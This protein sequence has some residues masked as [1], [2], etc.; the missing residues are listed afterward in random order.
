[1]SR[2]VDLLSDLVRNDTVGAREEESARR[3]AEILEEAGLAGSWLDFEPGRSQYV[4]RSGPADSA[5]LTFTGHLDVVPVSRGDWA[6]D[7]FSPEIDGD[8]MVGRGTSDMLS[9]VAA[10]V[11]AVAGHA[12]SPH[13]CRGVQVVLT[14]GEETGC[15][16][17][18]TI[19]RDVLAAGGPLVVAEPTANRLVPGHKG[20]H[21]LRLSAT[22]RAAHG[23]APELGDNAAVK[24]ARAAVALHEHTGWPD[25]VTANVGVLRAGA[26]TNVVPDAGELLLDIRTVSGVDAD[27]VHALV[28]EV[29]GP[30][31]LLADEVV[32]PP[33]TTSTSSPF[34]G[35]VGDA[36]TACGADGTPA[37]AARFFTDASALIPLLTPP[38]GPMTPT[39]ILGPGEPDQCH[40]A[41]EWCSLTRLEE[42]V[43]IYGELLRGWCGGRG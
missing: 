34:L 16:G 9:G 36:L 32:L 3:C 35:L 39:V 11:L 17:A 10:L 31:I 25:G 28:H 5:P 37:V 1:M 38:G 20:A 19:P 4:A 12:A 22:G 6:S 2:T 41:N 13:S 8:R 33:V 15:T 29:V 24:V 14:S 27:S 26:Q 23:S 40:V 21:W 7:P 18:L 42:A 43:E 30:E